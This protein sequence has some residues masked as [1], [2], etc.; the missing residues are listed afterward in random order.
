MKIDEAFNSKE[1][2]L[3]L[4]LNIKFDLAKS[5]YAD[6]I[7]KLMCERNPTVPMEQI[8]SKTINEIKLNSED[9]FY[10]LYVATI[11]D[12]VVGFCRFFHSKG[13][14]SHK[15]IF[16]SPEGWYGMGIMVSSQWRRK[17]IARFLSDERQKKLKELNV[18]EFYSIVDAENLTSIRM[19]QEFGFEKIDEAHG[20]LHLDFKD[21]KA[22]L[23]VL[24]IG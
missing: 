23:Y 6:A 18:K 14:P 22:F 3:S 2:S 8:I 19:H 15:K 11:D 12:V 7:I 9:P 20:F 24:N 4:P 1:K 10:W 5:E 16:A 17:N 13:M 21:R